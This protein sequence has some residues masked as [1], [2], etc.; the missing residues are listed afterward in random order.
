MDLV[1]IPFIFPG[2][3]GVRCLFQTPCLDKT[4][5]GTYPNDL[6]NHFPAD[7]EKK[8]FGRR[9]IMKQANISQLIE[10]EQ[11]HG[12]VLLFESEPTFYKGNAS[13]VTQQADGIS[14]TKKGVGLLIRTADC[15]PILLA[16]KSGH[17]IAAIHVGWRGNRI[18]FPQTAVKNFCS[19]YKVEPSEVLV[20]R[21]PSLS[22]AYAKFTSFQE[23]WDEDFDPWFSI[24]T[25]TMDLWELTCFQLKS[26]GILS[27]NIFSLDLCTYL[28]PELFFSY[29][30]DSKCGRQGSL[31]WIE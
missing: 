10:V 27:K 20:V 30:R 24:E 31:I 22:P 26:V 29:R 6:G 4:K 15:Q 19:Y 12:D 3:S 14:T 16:H 18:E 8:T 23:E 1:G 17:Y 28:L 9:R 13:G 11:V 25:E 2:V 21:G 7:I 5:E